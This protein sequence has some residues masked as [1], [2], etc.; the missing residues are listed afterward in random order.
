MP[1][2]PQNSTPA[3]KG[4]SCRCVFFSRTGQYP[5]YSPCAASKP[6]A[7]I[8]N[9]SSPAR[10]YCHCEGTCARGNLLHGA[11][12]ATVNA[13]YNKLFSE[14]P[15]GGKL[16][17]H[18]CCAPCSA[19]VVH[20]LRGFDAIPYYYNPNMDT[21]EEYEL[22]YAQFCKLGLKPVKEIYSHAEFLRVAD[23]L[24]NEPEG[25][26][27]CRACIA[28]RLER[29]AQKAKELGADLFCSTLSV[30]PH[31]DAEFINQTGFA[32]EKKYGVKYLPN[33]FK[34]ENGFAVSTRLSKELGLYRQNYCGCEFAKAIKHEIASSRCFS[35]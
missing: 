9:P 15:R 19:G 11:S 33:D 2:K 35:Q 21:A 18:V 25:G 17:L 3:N 29:T 16:L 30:S 24:E 7:A 8:C 12:K 26:A 5:K 4:A 14:Y 28:L 20:R 34:K 1:T 23:K 31:K 10:H 22:R 27:R 6:A 13:N 32:L